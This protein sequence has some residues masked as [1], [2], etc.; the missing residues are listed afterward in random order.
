MGICILWYVLHDVA[1][2]DQ[3][4]QNDKNQDH[5]FISF[6]DASVLLIGYGLYLVVCIN[7]DEIIHLL[8]C[9]IKVKANNHDLEFV[10]VSHL[11]VFERQVH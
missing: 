2:V 6:V 5:L 8:S 10:E 9:S 7:F 4:V 11:K 3:S 1:P